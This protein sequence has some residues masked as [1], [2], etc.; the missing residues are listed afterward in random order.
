[1]QL[2]EGDGVHAH[3]SARADRVEGIC[4]LPEPDSVLV[5]AHDRSVRSAAVPPPR[6][7]G[8]IGDSILGI[9][10]T[11]EER[12]K[13]RASA[14]VRVLRPGQDEAATAKEDAAYW[15]RIPVDKRA[16]FVWELSV[17]AFSLHA[18]Q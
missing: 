5:G 12:R 14:E 15:L 7:L 16:E 4:V 1:V 10:E 18:P 2:T 6:D 3:A 8:P 11:A 9:G 17:E 13:R